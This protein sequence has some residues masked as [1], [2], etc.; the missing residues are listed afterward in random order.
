MA[1]TARPASTIVGWECEVKLS[2]LN[3]PSDDTEH[4]LWLRWDTGGSGAG[5]L[6]G[7]YFELQ[8]GSDC[9]SAGVYRDSRVGI[10]PGSSFVDD[11]NTLDQGLGRCS[12][13]AY[14]YIRAST[15]S[16]GGRSG[17]ASE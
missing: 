1:Q 15:M 6:D 3:D 7:E 5:E 17:G 12:I 2:S 16:G 13:G 4:Y 8:S 14:L 10:A 11:I 9:A